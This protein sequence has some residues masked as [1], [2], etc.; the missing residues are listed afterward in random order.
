MMICLCAGAE[1]M[2]GRAMSGWSVASVSTT[3]A[4]SLLEL[5]LLRIYVNWLK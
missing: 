5:G 1:K 3:I 2:K 4:R